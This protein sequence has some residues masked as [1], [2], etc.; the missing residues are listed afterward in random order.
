[1]SHNVTAAQAE[2]LL[3][4]LL[5]NVSGGKIA[6]ALDVT[7]EFYTLGFVN[8]VID[9]VPNVAVE[10]TGHYAAPAPP[11]GS[12]FWTG[13]WN[14][15]AGAVQ[16]LWDA[17]RAAAVFVANV[18]AAAVQW[19]LSVVSA[20]VEAAYAAVKAV[21]KAVV[22]AILAV[23]KFFID[24]VKALFNPIV[25]LFEGL[26]EDVG[27]ALQSATG[28]LSKANPNEEEHARRAGIVVA[29][30]FT[31]MMFIFFSV[32]LILTAVDLVTGPVIWIA[33]I[34]IPALILILL[35]V[36]IS[37]SSGGNPG[38]ILP[39]DPDFVP[40]SVMSQIPG[41][42][43]QA[44]RAMWVFGRFVVSLGLFFTAESIG[45]W[46]YAGL[47]LAVLGVGSYLY[48]LTIDPKAN[49]MGAN[50][51]GA[52]VVAATGLV[53][54]VLGTIFTA[55]GGFIGGIIGIGVRLG[56]AVGLSLA[57]LG[58]AYLSLLRVGT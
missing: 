39:S 25:D 33:A 56:L 2:T 40:N 4:K 50:P 21:T 16:H 19:A 26:A 41:W 18:I 10:N 31:A 58:M 44:E 23:I 43:W 14:A 28:E 48:G 35:A 55:I 37:G 34:L 17:A 30:I 36:G 29:A 15:M 13:F 27:G 7:G 49:P 51:M 52:L 47:A 1:V 3:A 46:E 42:V 6:A 54:A 53:A 5:T 24:L 22:D 32:Y 12:A 57:S 8:D 45:K 20:F 11:P 9:L 38:W